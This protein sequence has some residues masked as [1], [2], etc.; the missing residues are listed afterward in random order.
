MFNA[1]DAEYNTKALFRGPPFRRLPAMGG[2]LLSS[3]NGIGRCTG[4]EMNRI[5]EVLPLIVDGLQLVDDKQC[6]ATL[7]TRF[8]AL[9]V[10]PSSRVEV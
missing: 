2:Q 9:C 3:D 8:L 10:P 1:V 5:L 7:V 6:P 4:E